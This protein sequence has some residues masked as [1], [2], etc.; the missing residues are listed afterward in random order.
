MPAVVNVNVKAPDEWASTRRGTQLSS[1]K[2]ELVWWPETGQAPTP[3]PPEA[4]V[5]FLVSVNEVDTCVHTRITS[6][7]AVFGQM[8]GHLQLAGRKARS[9]LEGEFA[10]LLSHLR[11]TANHPRLCG[12]DRCD[13]EYLWK[14]QP[15]A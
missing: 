12:H 5:S 2:Q 7:T 9:G 11:E 13:H 4:Q 1:G 14:L 15:T 6:S 10:C 8:H 3:G